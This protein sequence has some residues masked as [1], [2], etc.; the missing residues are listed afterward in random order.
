M[1]AVWRG[2]RRPAVGVR[3]EGPAAAAARAHAGRAR[4]ADAPSGAATRVDAQF[5]VPAANTDGTRPANIERVDVYALTGAA[6]AVRST[7]SSSAANAI[8]SVE[9]KAPRDPEPDDRSRRSGRAICEPLG[10]R[11]PRS[12]RDRRSSRISRRRGAR[13]SRR[14]STAGPT[15][16]RCSDRR[17]RCRPA[18][19]SAVGISTRGRRGLLSP[20][21]ARAA[22]AGAA[23]ACRS[24]RVELRRD[25]R[26]D[27]LAGAPRGRAGAG[28]AGVR[29]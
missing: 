9:V 5:V 18:P 2:R 3:Q 21:V 25:E 1:P 22:G 8:A 27:R 29:V 11:R 26:H 14:A 28:A 6:R 4:R 24:R 7:R 17:V 19:T 12:G 20:Q 13:R 15:A 10:G 23:A 16:S